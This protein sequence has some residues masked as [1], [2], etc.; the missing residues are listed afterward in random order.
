MPRNDV[1]RLRQHVETVRQDVKYAMRGFRREPTIMLVATIVLG[2]GIGANTAVFSIV[3]PLLL[4]ALPFPDSHQ[5]VWIANTGGTG[6]SGAT[7]RVDVFDGYRQHAKS[8]QEMTGYFAFFGFISRTLTGG[9]PERLSVVDV[10]PRFFDVLRVPPATGRL[11][12]Q[13]DHHHG[14]TPRAA[15]L[16]HGFWQRRFAGASGLV[17][18]TLTI[19][20]APVTIV[21]ILPEDFDFSS[22]FT[23][24]TRVDMFL[25]ADL[26]VLRPMGN[27]LALVGRLKPGVTLMEA[28]A[29]NDVLWPQLLAQHRD[30]RGWGATLTGLQEHV[31]GSMRRPLLVLW[32]AVGF[33]LL[34]VCA[35]LANLLLA[36][37]SMRRREFAV[38]FALGAR[39]SR[40]IRQLLTEGVLLALVGAV[41]GVALAYG[42]TRWFTSS[43]VVS[44][45]LLHYVRVDSAA[46]AVTIGVALMTGLVAAVVP[47]FRMS[48]RTPQDVLQEQGRGA[49]DSA[50]QTFVRNGLVV[51]EIALAAVLLVGAGLLSRSFIRLLD[52]DLGFS[53]ERVVAARLEFQG[54]PDRQQVVALTRELTRRVSELPG[55]EATGVTDALPLDRNRSWNVGVP[56]QT[57]ANNQRPGTF[58]Y[59]VGPGYFRAMGIGLKGGR[60][61]TDQDVLRDGG[62][63]A[64]RAVIINETLARTLY[65]GV[66]A[67]GR[68]A[69]TGITP[70]TIVGVVS[71]VRQSSLDEAPVAQMYLAWAQGGGAGQDLIV[72]TSLPRSTLLPLLRQTMADVDSQLIATDIRSIENLVETSVSPRRFLVSLL[73][74]FAILAL[75]LAGL[76]VYGVVS[77]GVNQRITEIGVRMAL[78]ATRADV[79]R[80]ILADTL[81]MTLLGTAIGAVV[82]IGLARV[83]SAL[84]FETS[85]TD[86]LTFIAML[87]L[88]GT[89][90][91]IAGL[92]PAA[93]ASGIDPMA[94][95]RAD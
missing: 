60:D 22:T 58:L 62:A 32:A 5:L 39:R 55:V 25:P 52:V 38:R 31:S 11:F 85:P 56:G 26:D 76:G 88:L 47:A 6:L 37:A 9:E 69:I 59:V 8:F 87:I 65:P 7:Y 51:A 57:Y 74:G 86:P 67:V 53:P 34:I 16:T 94:A 1:A 93:R 54:G 24:G 35:N 14:G 10:A 61:F 81:R 46:L 18:T 70:L 90:A 66:D 91:T 95:L 42:M 80:Q 77:Y 63:S 68:P 64:D 21:G 36:R 13:S 79:R 83:I 92:L 82:A 78:G 12:L 73:G 44:L 43:N 15:L 84:L 45:P 2:L 19:N 17:D 3:N 20:G 89:V 27:T 72:R 71:D 33:V 4:R 23:P 30:W 41:L 50:R 28:R 75:L 29:E 49:V 40:L 48:V